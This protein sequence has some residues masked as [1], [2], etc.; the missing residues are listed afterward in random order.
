MRR[1]LEFFYYER[2]LHKINSPRAESWGALFNCFGLLV[3]WRA[4]WIGAHY[5]SQHKRWGI[6]LLPCVTIWWTKPGGYLP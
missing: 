5:S 2:R 3:N 1:L 4:L 6:N